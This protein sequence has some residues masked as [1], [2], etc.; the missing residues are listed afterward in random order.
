MKMFHGKPVKKTVKKTPNETPEIQ[1]GR[2][3]VG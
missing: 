2:A 3:A 1:R